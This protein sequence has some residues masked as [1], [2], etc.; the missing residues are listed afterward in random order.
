ME[1]TKS[2][3]ISRF[4]ETMP[5]WRSQSTLYRYPRLASHFIDFIGVKQVYDKADAMR[6]LNHIINSGLSKNYAS[7]SGYVLKQFYESLGLTFPLQAGDLPKPSEDEIVAPVFSADYVHSLIKIVKSKGTPQMKAYLALSTT[8][9]F[10]RQELADISS[11]SINDSVIKVPTVK[12]KVLREHLV[13]DD[14]A[15]YLAGY[16]FKP[17]HPQTIINVFLRMQELAKLKHGDREGFHS[18]RR[19]L[20]TE[21]LNAGVPIHITYSFMGWKLSTRLGIIGIYA[22]PSPLEVDKVVMSKHPFISM[23]R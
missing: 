6:F 13:P 2:Q 9:G 3:L 18:I 8:Y 19:S 10:R 15:P 14:I 23:W 1:V 4:K 11:K 20:V 21:L 22:R 12:G 16:K 7:W 17:V 5:A